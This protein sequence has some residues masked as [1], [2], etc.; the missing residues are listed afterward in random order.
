M[1][2]RYDTSSLIRDAVMSSLQNEE[3]AFLKRVWTSPS[4]KKS[5]PGKEIFLEMLTTSVVRKRDPGEL[6]S[7]LS[8]LDAD[9]N[10]PSWKEEAVITGMS[11]QSRNNIKPIRLAS[12][13]KILDAD[14]L[15]EKLQTIAAMFEWPGHVVDINRVTKKS[16]LNENELKLFVSGRQLYLATCASCHGSD[17]RGMNRFAPTLVASEWVLGDE[18]RLSLILL[19]GIEGPIEVSGKRYDIPD[20]LPV[21]PSHSTMDDGSIAAILTY[22]RNEWGNSAGAVSPRTVGTT[23][24]TSQGRVIPWTSKEINSHMQERKLR[25]EGAIEKAK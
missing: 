21:M 22:I 11:I 15:D 25:E 9:K 7:V 18:Q 1:V 17:G 5:S 3:F 2:E 19:H 16:M 24:V 10:S 13:P 8:L 14:S 4:W 6:S 12:A 20:I 23:R